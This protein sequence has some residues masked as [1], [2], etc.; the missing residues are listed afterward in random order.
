M[1][2]SQQM[3][4]VVIAT[5][6][7]TPTLPL[8][9]AALKAV[10]LPAEGVEI[11]AVDNASDDAS[12]AL[13]AEY[14][15][16]LP[17]T[18]LSEPRRGKSFALNR[19]LA[20]ARGDLVVFADDDILPDPQWL[21]A[22]RTAA[23]RQPD[24]DLFAGQVRHFWQKEPPR[25]L[26]RLAAEGRSYAG[27]PIDLAEGPADVSVFKG[28]N[29][30]AR[31]R[32]LESVMFSERPGLNFGDTAG[33]AGGEDSAFVHE[34]LVQGYRAR[35]VPAACVKHIVR[36][37]QVGLAPVLRRYLRIG[38]AMTLSNPDQFDPEGAQLFGYPRYIFKSVPRD[39]LRAL[40]HWVAGNSH[41]AAGELIGVAMTCGRAQQW[42][43]G[44]AGTRR[45]EK[46][47]KEGV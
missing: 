42:R 20:A 16:A 34:A 10:E 45:A 41:A 37:Y 22:Y 14:Q 25:W 3:I 29:F 31:R 40:R 26:C 15:D 17:L 13:L 8:M 44:R 1:R 39:L 18:V 7:G 38:R 6:N 32:V 30:M 9:L 24:C 23:E 4:S 2:E 11:I 35:Y 36:P 43:R 5:H 47:S 21:E 27:T 46:L 12:A 33:S 19:A 28:L